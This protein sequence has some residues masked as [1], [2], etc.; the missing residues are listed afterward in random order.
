MASERGNINIEPAGPPPGAVSAL[1]HAEPPPGAVS[2]LRLS[3]DAEKVVDSHIGEHV[4]ATPW[5]FWA[6]GFAAFGAVGYGFYKLL[7]KTA[8]VLL[9]LAFG[10]PPEAALAMGQLGAVAGQLGGAARQPA[11][12]HAPGAQPALAP[13]PASG[14]VD[15]SALSALIGALPPGSPAKSLE[16]ILS[17]APALGARSSATANALSQIAGAQIA[18]AG[19]AGP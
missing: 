5:W 2:A 12:E 4:N 1:R 15:P 17:L 14:P 7:D 3:D 8:P 11:P 6:L 19:K 10:V 9:P 16:A 18:A 13:S